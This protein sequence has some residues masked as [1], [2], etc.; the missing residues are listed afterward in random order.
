[1]RAQ[2][3]SGEVISV[4]SEGRYLIVMP[5]KGEVSVDGQVLQ[6]EE[7]ALTTTSSGVITIKSLNQQVSV[8]VCYPK[9]RC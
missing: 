1:V 2:M 6:A 9:P 8:L 5:A 4:A 3:L 7:A